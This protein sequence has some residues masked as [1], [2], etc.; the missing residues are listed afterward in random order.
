M[1]TKDC[2]ML[3]KNMVKWV[4]EETVN[5]DSLWVHNEERPNMEWICGEDKQIVLI[6]SYELWE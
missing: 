1:I 3:K 6:S 4:C 2:I 5:G